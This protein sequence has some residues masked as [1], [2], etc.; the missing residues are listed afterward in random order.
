M[1]EEQ[2][3]ISKDEVQE[4]V[5]ETNDLIKENSYLQRRLKEAKNTR[6]TG[7]VYIG[8]TRVDLRWV[9]GISIVWN[10]LL[11]FYVATI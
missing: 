3:E 7:V 6:A 5:D 10:I 11:L 8:S 1:T 9:A 2:I 4:L